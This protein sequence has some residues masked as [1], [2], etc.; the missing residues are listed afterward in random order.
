MKKLFL[1]TSLAAVSVFASAQYTLGFKTGFNTSLGFDKDWHYNEQNWNLKSDLAK[2]LQVGTFARFGR[3]FYVQPEFNYNLNIAKIHYSYNNQLI[4][5][6]LILSTLEFPV[7]FGYKAVNTKLFNLR[8]MAGPKFRFNAGSDTSIDNV[9]DL[10]L[11]AR[12]AQIGLDAGLGFDV[13]RFS[14]DVRYN[15]IQQLYHYKTVDQQEI[16]MAPIN[17]FTVSVG[18]KLLDTYKAKHY[19]NKNNEVIKR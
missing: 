16:N 7:L 9:Q 15:L 2:G 4:T 5:D 19:Y 18:W 14:V 11:E 1:I 12:K 3:T 8:F 10:I 6:D 13:W 17:S